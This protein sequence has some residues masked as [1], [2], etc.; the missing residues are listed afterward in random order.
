MAFFQRDHRHRHSTQARIP[1]NHRAVVAVAAVTVQ[2]KEFF[3]YVLNKSRP[4]GRPAARAAR[5][6]PSRSYRGLL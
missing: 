1:R 5:I 6:Y 4:V 3:E 2:L